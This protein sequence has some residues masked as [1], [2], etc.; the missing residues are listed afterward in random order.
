MLAAGLEGVTSEADPGPPVNKNIFTMSHREKRRLR[1]DEL[2][3]NLSEALTAMK[4][5]ALI[6]EAL[7][8]HI[9]QHFVEAKTKAWEDYSAEVHPWEVDR[10]LAR[11]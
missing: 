6:R 9:Y 7:G 8:D 5:D 4:K 3:S 1:V 11:Y 10:Y 2:P